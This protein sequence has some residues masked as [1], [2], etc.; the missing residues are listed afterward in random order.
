MGLAQQGVVVA[1]GNPLMVQGVIPAGV[2]AKG[3]IV[4]R[5]A[6]WTMLSHASI[7]GGGNTVTLDTTGANL[8]VLCAAYYAG[9][10]VISDS[11]SNTWTNAVNIGSF[12]VSVISYCINPATSAQ[13][14]VN[15]NANFAVMMVAAFEAP[16]AFV[17][18]QTVTYSDGGGITTVPMPAIDAA[19]N[20]LLVTTIG[21]GYSTAAIDSGFTLIASFPRG[22]NYGGAAAFGTASNAAS[23][24]PTWTLANLVTAGSTAATMLSFKPS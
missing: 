5:N 23:V 18:D 17:A 3:S 8:I 2:A 11:Q 13:H 10:F 9:T 22:G 1:S 14:V 21:H 20:S 24:S 15:L 6:V 16:A 4:Y 19:A 7:Q 12:P